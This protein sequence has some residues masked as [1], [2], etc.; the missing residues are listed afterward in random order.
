MTNNDDTFGSAQ[1]PPQGVPVNPGMGAA[2]TTPGTD[3]RMSNPQSGTTYQILLPQYQ[4]HQLSIHELA[5]LVTAGQLN[6]DTSVQASNSNFPMRAADIP[7][8]FSDKEFV[9]T[10]ILSAVLGSLGVDRF[11]LGYT[12]LGILKLLT[13]GGCGIWALIDLIL[14]AMRK[15]PDSDNRPLR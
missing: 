11:Y 2:G 6:A 4:G 5:N 10:L 9:T 12:G 15:L 13:L 14:I 3:P 8:L 7:N 1:P